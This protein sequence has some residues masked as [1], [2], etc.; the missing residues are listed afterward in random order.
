M[1]NQ[2]EEVFE[3]KQAAPVDFTGY[4]GYAHMQPFYIDDSGDGRGQHE[5]DEEGGVQQPNVLQL[6][7]GGSSQE[8][9]H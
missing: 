9:N 3:N 1:Y 8:N 7:Y 6:E 4:P 2:C 5:E